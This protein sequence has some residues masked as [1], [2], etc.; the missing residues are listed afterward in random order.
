[1]AIY[2]PNCGQQNDD[3]ATTCVHCGAGWAPGQPFGMPLQGQVMPPPAYAVPRTNP[4]AIASLV[5]SILGCCLMLAVAGVVMGHIARKQIRDS[6]GRETG[7]GL[8]L[9]GLIVGYV[10]VGLLVI[11]YA[12]IIGISIMAQHHPR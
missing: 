9:A 7:D 5:C 11:Y 6:G 4:M 1:M 2:C 12:V 8:A 3:A 10:W